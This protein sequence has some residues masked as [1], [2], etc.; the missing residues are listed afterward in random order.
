M[1]KQKAPA[2][3]VTY[4]GKA[5]MSDYMLIENVIA[6]KSMP[7]IT[8]SGPCAY[9]DAGDYSLIGTVEIIITLH[10]NDKIVQ[11]QIEALNAKMEKNRADAHMAEQAI[12]E[13]ISKLSALTFEGG[14]V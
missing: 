3:K 8:D 14:E 13:K 12:L 1:T 4:Q 10:S 5:Y 11:N 9:L 6:G 2:A 7:I